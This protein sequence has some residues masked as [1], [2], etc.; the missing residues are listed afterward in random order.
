MTKLAIFDIGLCDML[1]EA[2]SAGV[3]VKFFRREYG[4]LL[5]RALQTP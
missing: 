2:F 4:R 1:I 3:A 5:L